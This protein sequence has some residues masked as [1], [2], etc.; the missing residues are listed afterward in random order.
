MSELK[1]ESRANVLVVYDF[2]ENLLLIKGILKKLDV[3]LIFAKS[4]EE[5]LSKIKDKEIALAL[6]DIHMSVID[7]VKLAEE[8]Q[9][10]SAEQIPII[11][12][13]TA[14]LKDEVELDTYYKTGVVD[15]IHKPFRKNILLGKVEVFLELYQQRQ[16]I[17]EQKNEIQNHVNE[18]EIVNQSLNKRLD[19]ESILSQISEMAVTVHDIVQFSSAVLSLIGETLNLCRT[20]FFEYLEATNTLKNTQVWCKKGISPNKEFF[21]GIS[22]TLLS[23]A[24]EVLKR[25][26]IF[27]YS[28]IES[29]PRSDLYF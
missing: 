22:A 29:T 11:I 18:L 24:I 27:N 8:I 5:A 9:K 3:N 23:F 13:I 28:N 1:F 15:F 26:K 21:K 16:K 17:K 6:F 10:V 2:P 4:G 20:Y 12:F 19:Y 7:G 14:Y 25:D